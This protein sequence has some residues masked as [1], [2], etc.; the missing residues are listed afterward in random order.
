MATDTFLRDWVIGGEE[1]E[2]QISNYLKEIQIKNNTFTSFFTLYSRKSSAQNQRVRL[3][4]R[5]MV[6]WCTQR[7]VATSQFK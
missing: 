1:G 7:F 5:K 3:P 4:T 6:R 2:Q